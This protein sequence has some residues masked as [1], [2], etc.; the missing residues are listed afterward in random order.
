MKKHKHIIWILVTSIMFLTAGWKSQPTMSMASPKPVS[1]KGQGLELAAKVYSSEDSKEYLHRDLIAQ[2]FIPVEVSINNNTGKSYAISGASVPMSCAT[3]SQVAWSITKK[4]LPRSIGL[5]IASFFFWPFM[6]PSTIDSIH[7]Y[8]SHRSM[9]KDL[10]A[11]TLKEKDE[12][13]PPYA[14]VKRIIY[15]KKDS[16]RNDF[17]FS[18]QE[19]GGKDLKVV[20]LKVDS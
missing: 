10:T 14:A 13:I 2:G 7:G 8:K 17:S 9:V 4:S 3:P 12:V 19:V 16:M 11:K 20:P 1:F 5:K 6:I 18:L 15:V